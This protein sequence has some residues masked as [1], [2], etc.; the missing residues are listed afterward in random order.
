VA[1]EAAALALVLQLV[2]R[3]C[4]STLGS[5][6]CAAQV[7][8]RVPVVQAV[9]LRLLG[10]PRTTPTVLA[11]MAM[12]AVAAARRGAPAAGGSSLFCRTAPLGR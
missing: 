6:G 2:R 4:R 1:A 3:G 5:R 9:E 11:T 10:R 12:N 7:L 8:W